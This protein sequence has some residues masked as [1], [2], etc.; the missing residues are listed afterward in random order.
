L[1]QPPTLA[2]NVADECERQTDSTWRRNEIARSFDRAETARA[3]VVLT[4]PEASAA[5]AA[6]AAAAALSRR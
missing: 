1:R 4:H 6:A 2:D 3:L 5:A